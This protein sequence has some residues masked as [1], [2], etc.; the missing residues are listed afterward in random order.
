MKLYGIFDQNKNYKLLRYSTDEQTSRV[1]Q[2]FDYTTKTYY[3]VSEICL[4]NIEYAD[5]NIGKYY[6]SATDTF[7]D[8]PL[9]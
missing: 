3:E 9:S 2:E 1:Y 4:P 8:D 5:S 7:S 6:N